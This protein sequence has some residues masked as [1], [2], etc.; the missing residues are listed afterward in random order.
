MRGGSWWC[1]SSRPGDFDICHFSCGS[2]LA[3]TRCLAGEWDED[4]AAGARFSCPCPGPPPGTGLTCDATPDPAG[5][6]PGGA[7][8]AL[9]CAPATFTEC[10]NGGWTE[11]LSLGPEC[12]GP[13]SGW[14]VAGMGLLLVVAL[15]ALAATIVLLR[16]GRGRRAG[17]RGGGPRSIGGSSSGGSE[18]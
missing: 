4:T 6:W 12:A 8:C 18:A 14:L 16:P 2:S 17:R 15:V 10:F 5:A 7:R 9:P 3:S 13:A 1:N 11:D